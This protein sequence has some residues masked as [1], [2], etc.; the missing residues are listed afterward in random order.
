MNKTD[1]IV[2]AIEPGIKATLVTIAKNEGLTLS[3][4]V[5]RAVNQLIE[6][7]MENETN[8]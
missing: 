1:K 4:I 6:K 8:N 5:R 7:E 2:I 3:D